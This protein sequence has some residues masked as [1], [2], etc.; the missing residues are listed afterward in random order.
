M[1]DFSFNKA[2]ILGVG[3]IGA[4]CALALKGKGLCT[5]ISG[6][7]R[8]EANLAE[9][10]KR[11]IIDE[12]HL[13]AA[14][15]CE[16][17]DLII[18]ATPVGLFKEL[19]GKIRGSLKKGALVTDVGSVK[20]KL[21]Y[22]LELLMPEGVHFI[23]AHPIAGSDKSGIDEARADLFVD[24]QCFITPTAH[25]NREAM[26]K[27]IALWKAVGAKVDVMD[28]F[29]HDEIYAAVSHLPHIAAYALVNTVGDIN[30]EYISYAGQGFKDATRIALS[31]PEMWRDI[32]M[33]NKDHL[34]KQIDILQDNLDNIK[35]LIEAAD[36]AGI[37]SEF[38]KA[39]TLRKK[40][41]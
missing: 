22:D 39:Q 23:G 26:E 10:K 35:R 12:Y 32:A 27:I 36:A 34:V 41:K 33:L 38:K 15:A 20:G 6:Y 13:D 28:P 16:G 19:A 17:A 2:T 30:A 11:A 37:E 7:G 1:H 5:T 25:S 18:L 3:L 21:V 9:A 29:R 4:S 8:R 14:K 31:S 24:A 40:L